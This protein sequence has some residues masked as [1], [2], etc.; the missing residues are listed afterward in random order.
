MSRM[1]RKQILLDEETDS[2]LEALAAERGVSQSE[3]VREALGGLM[4]EANAAAERDAA[5]ER[6]EAGWRR[7]GEE[8]RRRAERGEPVPAERGWTR[9]ELYDD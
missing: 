8:A 4:E 1:V 9:D 5:W 6:L 3:L 7:V 2:R